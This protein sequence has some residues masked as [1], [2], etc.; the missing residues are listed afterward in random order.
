[1]RITIRGFD[2]QNCQILQL[3]RFFFYVCYPEAF[4]KGVQDT[5]ESFS[6]N[7]EHQ[8]LQNMNFKFSYFCVYFLPSRIRIQ[9]PKIK[10]DPGST[11]PQQ[12]KS[13]IT[14]YRYIRYREGSTQPHAYCRYRT[15]MRKPVKIRS[16]VCIYLYCASY[17]DSL[18]CM[19]VKCSVHDA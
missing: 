9:S 16:I 7:R 12:P 10:A 11:T 13:L 19:K 5:R 15:R 14:G 1:M 18:N 3:K 2:D 17:A 8:A 6:L 4:T